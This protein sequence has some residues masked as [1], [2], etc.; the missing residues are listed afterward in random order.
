[1]EGS[2]VGVFKVE[3]RGEVG[4]V[5]EVKRKSSGITRG[6]EADSLGSLAKWFLSK[7]PMNRPRPARNWLESF[8]G[9]ESIKR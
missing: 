9:E 4:T 6:M 7:R 1:M 8:R 5:R 2:L 3:G